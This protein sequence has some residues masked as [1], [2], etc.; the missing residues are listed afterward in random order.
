MLNPSLQKPAHNQDWLNLFHFTITFTWSLDYSK[1]P[2]LRHV[3][4]EESSKIKGLHMVH[5]KKYLFFNVFSTYE[6]EK[7]AYF[8][9][10]W[11]HI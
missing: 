11:S 5:I 4:Y 6:G 9:C 1:S 10:V 3:H 8:R 7:M 2:H